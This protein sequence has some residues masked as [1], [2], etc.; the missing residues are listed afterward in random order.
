[1]DGGSRYAIYF[2]P[3]AQSE[4]Y[5]CGS[6]ILGYDCHTGAVIDFPDALKCGAPDWRQL[7]SE[8]RRYGFHATLKAPFRLCEPHSEAQ[9]IEALH[10]FVRRHD[11]VHIAKPA[12]RL[13]DG[14]VAIVPSEPMP[15]L[16]ALAASCTTAFD[17]FRAPLSPQERDRRMAAGLSERQIENLDRWGYP[18]VLADFR[19]HMTLTGTLEV[20]WREKRLGLLSTCVQHMGGGRPFAVDRL[21]LVKQDTPQDYF[22]VVSQAMLG[23]RVT[24]LRSR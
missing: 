4:L 20:P 2:V 1:V 23:G 18:Y 19:F 17:C 9:L 6:A 14:F 13:L 3:D 11:A 15:A 24:S 8:P 7:T 21:A 10:D 16:D 5:R 12:V 22:K